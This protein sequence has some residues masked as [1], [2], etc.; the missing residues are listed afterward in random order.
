MPRKRRRR[1]IRKEPL[2][3]AIKLYLGLVAFSLAG[4]LLSSLTGLDPGPIAPGAALLTLATGLVAAFSPVAKELGRRRFAAVA[5]A[6]LAVGAT[7]EIVGLY[8][9]Y[10]FGSYRY[11]GQWWP[12]VALPGE[13]WFP[14]QLPFAWLMVAGAAYLAAA[15]ALFGVAAVVAGALLATLID[16]P[17]EPV[18]TG[19]LG[20]W[21]WLE[22][23]PLLGAPLLNPVGWFITSFVAAALLYR[24]GAWRVAYRREPGL[25]LLGHLA[26][27]L[28]MWLIHA[29]TRQ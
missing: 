7:S 22:P 23:G 8:T 29:L 5:G 20:Y 1:K 24:A 13:H 16:V 9:G 4:T 11:T 10:P 14:L 26:L 27:V 28:G 2:S 6:I 19:V 21:V 3:R 15:R 25:V 12:S 17:M 18:M